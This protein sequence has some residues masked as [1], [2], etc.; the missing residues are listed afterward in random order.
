MTFADIIVVAYAVIVV[1]QDELD[2]AEKIIKSN[3]EIR[4]VLIDYDQTGSKSMSLFSKGD[5]DDDEYDDDEV[6]DDDND[7][8]VDDD[9][10]DEVDDDDGDDDEC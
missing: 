8:E 6:D 1:I 5:D 9:D 10:N 4:Q 2:A 7:D 3:K